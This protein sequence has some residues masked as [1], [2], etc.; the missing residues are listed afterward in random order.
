[1]TWLHFSSIRVARTHGS[2]ESIAGILPATH[3]RMRARY[4]SSRTHR[5]DRGGA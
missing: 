5:A 3:A 2:P 1:M 4:L